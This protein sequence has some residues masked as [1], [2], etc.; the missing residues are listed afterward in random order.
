MS[1]RHFGQHV[2][3]CGSV[4][5]KVLVLFPQSGNLI[6][7]TVPNSLRSIY[8]NTGIWHHISIIQSYQCS[9]RP[10]C[11]YLQVS[12][13]R[14]AACPSEIAKIHHT[15]WNHI[16]GDSNLHIDFCENFR[17]NIYCVKRQTEDF[18]CCLT[19][20][21]WVLYP[22]LILETDTLFPMNRI[23]I[24]FQYNTISLLQLTFLS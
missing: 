13:K 6:L 1:N 11:P 21:F 19:F 16:P 15:I 7:I 18:T 17:F 14:G 4:P 9:R 23:I 20:K 10:W 8:W 12:L 2:C 22:A 3:G 24:Q 5:N